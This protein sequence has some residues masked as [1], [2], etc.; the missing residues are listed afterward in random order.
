[1][2]PW[3]TAHGDEDCMRCYKCHKRGHWAQD[4]VFDSGRQSLVS[5]PTSRASPYVLGR[6]K[7]E[8]KRKGMY[9][10]GKHRKGEFTLGA[11]KEAPPPPRPTQGVYV[12]KM[13]GGKYYVGK[14]RNIEERLRQH[15]AGE[16]AACAKGKCT[17]VPPMTERMADMEAWERAET[18]ARMF[19]HGID[20]V[21]GWMYTTPQ[22]SPEMRE[23]AFLQI[24][25]RFDLCRRCGRKS[26][27]ITECRVSSR[28]HWADAA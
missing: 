4:C 26:H 28:A 10:V 9:V 19:G 25:E 16:G 14:S 3:D 8:S 1:M 23:H 13:D 24:C 21:R 15:A 20:K 2:A 5:R 22:L 27:F 18:L 6:V 7:P 12:L 17:Q 11:K